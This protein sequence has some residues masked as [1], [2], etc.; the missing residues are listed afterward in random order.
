M[1]WIN[2]TKLLGFSDR[3]PNV[4]SNS[5]DDFNTVKDAID[6]LAG[7]SGSVPD[8]TVQ[9][10][11]DD[12]ATNASNIATNTSDIATN[13]SD[14]ATNASDIS[15][16]QS[17]P[18][19]PAN[20][21]IGLGISNDT[22]TDH[23]IQVDTGSCI[24]STDTYKLT[25]SSALVKQI[26]ALWAVGDAAGGR[27]FESFG[28]AASTSPEV[29]ESDTTS[30]ISVARLTDSKAIVTY[31][32]VNNSG[33]GTACILDLV[34]STITAATPVPFESVSVA[35]T[36]VTMLTSTKALV[37][38]TATSS[39]YIGRACVLNITGSTITPATPMTFESDYIGECMVTALSST[40]AVVAYRNNTEGDDGNARVLSISGS[41]VTAGDPATFESS[42]YTAVS[43]ID[44]LTSSKA[45]VSY[46]GANNVCV[47]DI[48]GTSITPA[49][50]ASISDSG[51]YVSIAALNSTQ[52][53]AMYQQTS[54]FKGVYCLL[55]ISGSTITV[56]SS[57]VF[58]DNSISYIKA[59]A[60]SSTI[61]IAVYQDDGNSN[62]G[63]SCSF[64]IAGS[65]VTAETPV[66]FESAESL[67][68]SVCVMG[69]S[70]AV[71]VYR[72][73]GNSNYGTAIA[74]DSLLQANS[75]Y[76]LYVIRKDS[77][78]SIDALFS[79]NATTPAMPSG[80]TYFRRIRGAVLTDGS[81][82]IIGFIQ[83]N[84]YFYF[85]Y[86]ISNASGSNP[87]TSA[88]LVT[89]SV[90]PNMLGIFSLGSVNGDGTWCYTYFTSP[91]ITDNTPTQL[92]SDLAA[93]ATSTVSRAERTI[94]VDSSS[95]IRHRSTYS[96]ANVYV[97]I[98]TI[99]FIDSAQD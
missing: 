33:Y 91:D 1:S 99:G 18:L 89:T 70:Q 40:G 68:F 8:K 81:S 41:T 17:N 9:Q 31:R 88:V 16:L 28:K 52:V 59:T 37:V 80:Y 5:A 66:V 12:I 56:G 7:N 44:L 15:S 21:I 98:S 24:D 3:V 14:I 30:D 75:W 87:G 6:E 45:I 27:A 71:T 93:E 57:T 58:V 53:I 26:D 79:L 23:D 36:S 42:Q 84:D 85:D 76:Y 13:A 2:L 97:L 29:F 73:V 54:T 20:Y 47:L 82:N 25:L 50:P 51:N 43:G 63:T 19:L 46:T 92:L 74:L 67:D 60:L 86:H 69:E 48:T 72:D 77:D 22:D 95:Q 61:A 32:D 65:T 35:D 55:D 78:G 39:S 34:G 49:T 38:Y 96:S 64:Q 90:P 11:A 62:Y 10:N 83:K 94:K 4:D